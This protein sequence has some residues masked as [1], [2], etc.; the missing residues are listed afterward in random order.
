MARDS[1]DQLTTEWWTSARTTRY[2]ELELRMRREKPPELA[3]PRALYARLLA[4][5]TGHG[6][7]AAYHRRWNHESAT[8]AYPCGRETSVGHLVECR[9]A[10][11]NWRTISG[12]WRAPALHGMLGEGGWKTF[13]EYVIAS[14]IYKNSSIGAYK[15]TCTRVL[16]HKTSILPMEIYLKHRRVQ[17]AR[18]TYNLSVQKT[19]EKTCRMIRQQGKGKDNHRRSSKE[20]DIEEWS[21]I[22]YGEVYI[23]GQK[24]LGKIAAFREWENSWPHQCRNEA[25]RQRCCAWVKRDYVEHGWQP[26]G[27]KRQKSLVLLVARIKVVLLED[28]QVHMQVKILFPWVKAQKEGKAR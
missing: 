13:A 28:M 25:L 23:K 10:L 2:A 11:A 27:G 6:N 17:H 12:R 22:C 21:R 9:R 20:N 8:L 16:E 14:G 5:R 1:S 4:A 15:S 7:F 26:T 18:L 19:I 24:E 3:L